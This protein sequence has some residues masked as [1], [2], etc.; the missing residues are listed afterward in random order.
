MSLNPVELFA[1]SDAQQI[2][3]TLSEHSRS[4]PIR[5]PEAARS[6]LFSVAQDKI[7]LLATADP[8]TVVVESTSWVGTVS[9]PGVSIRVRPDAPMHS[10]FAMLAGLGDDIAWGQDESDFAQ[11]DLLDGSALM[12]LRTIDVATRRGLVHGYQTREEELSTLRGRLLI[13]QLAR[14]PWAIAQPPCRYDEFTADIA[15]NRLLR[16]AV[17]TILSA[18][19]LTPGT[20]REAH[21]LLARFEGVSDVDPR[22]LPADILITRLNEHY[23]SAIGLARLA[24][25]GFSIQH[26]EGVNGANAFLV[27][28][29]YVFLRFVAAQLRQRLW[30]TFTVDSGQA[31]AVDDTAS[32]ESTADI[33][34]TDKDGP[35]LVLGAPYHLGSADAPSSSVASGYHAPLG[36]V[37]ASLRPMAKVASDA[38]S[39]YPVMVQAA[40]LGLPVA[41][42]VY[43]HAARRP[44]SRIR[45]PG[46]S[47]TVHSWHVDLDQPFDGLSANLDALADQVRRMLGVASG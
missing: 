19:G 42:V 1:A 23:R 35:A 24:L 12:V 13:E 32:L 45:M 7:R 15:E 4:E 30:P 18:V 2:R 6:A 38:A 31:L 3:I 46:T 26:E 40:S 47:V 21:Q 41:L 39:F 11:G 27:D 8:T 43:A 22:S 34:V 33:I 28:V 10:V 20:R 36:R 29:D 44:A 5:L 9:A 16:A 17:V 37:P 14:R 25:E